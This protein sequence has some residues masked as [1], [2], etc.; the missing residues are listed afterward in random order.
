M[1]SSTLP[2]TSALDEGGWSKPRPGRLTPGKETR[3]P[4]YGRRFGPPGLS[5]LLR[6][7]SPSPGFDSRTVHP[8]S[9]GIIDYL[10]VDHDRFLSQPFQFVVDCV[11]IARYI[12]LAIDSV[13]K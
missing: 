1:H 11:I 13:V 12:M 9:D 7:I 5:G 6:K 3:Y 2:S 8:V 4:L 10:I